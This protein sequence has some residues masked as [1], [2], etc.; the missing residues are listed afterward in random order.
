MS[1]DFV[2]LSY[3][4]MSSPPQSMFEFV[5]YTDAATWGAPTVA[6]PLWLIE[7]EVVVEFRGLA[8]T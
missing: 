8:S 6:T 3:A 5:V 1:K 2:D 7:P 4:I